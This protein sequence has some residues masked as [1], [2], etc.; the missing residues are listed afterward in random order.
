MKSRI[1]LCINLYFYI[2]IIQIMTY[3]LSWYVCAYKYPYKVMCHMLEISYMASFPVCGTEGAS[4]NSSIVP[5]QSKTCGIPI[6]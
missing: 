3:M 1:D 2:I 4:R 5:C 6:H